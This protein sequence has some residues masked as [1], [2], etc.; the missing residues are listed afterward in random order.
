MQKC[1]YVCIMVKYLAKEI[2]N[3]VS[4]HYKLGR[5]KDAKYSSD[6]NPVSKKLNFCLIWRIVH[7]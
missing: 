3:L 7:A 1:H 6:T 4:T 2:L 5:L